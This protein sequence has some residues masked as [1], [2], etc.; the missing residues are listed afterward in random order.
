MSNAARAFIGWFGPRGLNSLLLALLVFQHG[1]VNAQF[2]LAVTGVVVAVSVV[3]HG[4]SATPLSTLYGRAVER[5][6]YG[7]E[8]ESTVAGLFG[9]AAQETPA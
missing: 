9:G 4:I 6:T 7:E 1:V 8:R 5:A 2:L 3:A